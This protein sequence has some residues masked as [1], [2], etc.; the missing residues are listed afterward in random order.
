MR[1]WVRVAREVVLALGKEQTVLFQN[2]ADQR[3]EV[4]VQDKTGDR[5]NQ[6][7]VHEGARDRLQRLVESR[8]R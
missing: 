5:K 1:S 4:L 8:S 3:V 7:T 2:V 6:W